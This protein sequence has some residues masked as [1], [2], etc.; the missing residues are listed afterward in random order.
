MAPDLAAARIAL[1]LR[2]GV[3]GTRRAPTALAGY[4]RFA[5]EVVAEAGPAVLAAIVRAVEEGSP[6][7]RGVA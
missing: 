1:A 4:G 2:P 5:G 6:T 7:G 3:D